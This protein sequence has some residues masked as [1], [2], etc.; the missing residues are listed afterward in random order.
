MRGK[1][2]GYDCGP[3]NVLVSFKGKRVCGSTAVMPRFSKLIAMINMHRRMFFSVVRQQHVEDSNFPSVRLTLKRR[4]Y[5]EVSMRMS[6]CPAEY[7]A[8]SNLQT[9]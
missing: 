4:Q 5:R 3:L 1:E 9:G 7:H 8:P 6:H 2:E